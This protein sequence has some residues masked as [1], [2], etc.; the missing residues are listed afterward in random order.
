MYLLFA[1]GRYFTTKTFSPYGSPR[2]MRKMY[3]NGSDVSPYEDPYPK[4]IDLEYEK[5][6][7][8]LDYIN[9]KF[10]IGYDVGGKVKY[11]ALNKI[12]N[13][14]LLSQIGSKSLYFIEEDGYFIT[15]LKNKKYI[16]THVTHHLTLSEYKM[17]F[18]DQ[19]KITLLP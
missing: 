3:E 7:I 9:N 18:N 11:F 4:V 13:T 6:P 14:I 10:R 15:E 17:A 5:E 16:L 12:D 19:F 8:I 1:S 2:M